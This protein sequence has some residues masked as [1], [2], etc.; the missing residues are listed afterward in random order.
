MDDLGIVGPGNAGTKTKRQTGG[1]AGANSGKPDDRYS[2]G[3]A[4]ARLAL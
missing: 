2:V 4:A 3:A 1:E